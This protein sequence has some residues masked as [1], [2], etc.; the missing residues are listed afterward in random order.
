MPASSSQPITP[1]I[2]IGGVRKCGT[3]ALFRWLQAHPD[4]CASS[5]KETQFLM[6]RESPY[7]DQAIGWHD[8]GIEGYAHFFRDWNGEPFRV[9]ASSRYYDQD[10][11]LRVLSTLA[12]P[13]H[14]VFVVREPIER[15]ESAFHY[16]KN[17]R[18]TLREDVSLADFVE[19]ASNN[20]IRPLLAIS[21][22]SKL[23]QSVQNEVSQLAKE[24][25][26]GH[27][28]DR[29]ARWQEHYPKTH[30]HVLLF[31]HL[32]HD[33]RR[34]VQGL[35]ARVGLAPSFYDDFAFRKENRTV[36]MRN[37]RVHRMMRRLAQFVP[38]NSLTRSAYNLYLKAQ[39]KPASKLSS[40]DDTR[41]KLHS[42]Y[43]SSNDRLATMFDLDLD[44]WN[45]H[46]ESSPVTVTTPAS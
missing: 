36:A 26:Y 3:T 12:D 1:N 45:S 20:N 28:V 42:L 17:N 43:A 35:A 15:L 46:P 27:Y 2:V 21:E 22:N 11:A 40:N 25:D 38:R 41:Q 5:A 6:D 39:G 29:L 19:A 14:V 37:L 16:A 7:Y 31:E 4:V 8:V 9:E 44:A 32:R 18:G 24:V 34:F 13:P 33:P 30:L 10:T 23:G